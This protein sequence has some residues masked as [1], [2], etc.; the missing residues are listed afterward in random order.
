MGINNAERIDRYKNAIQSRFAALKAIDR[1]D[2]LVANSIRLPEG[3]GYLLCVSQLHVTDE[4][5]INLLAKWR[6]EATTFHNKFNV[7]FAS[8]ERWLRQLLLAVPDRILFLV[9]NR[10]GYPIGHMGF[11]NSLNDECMLEFD[12]VIRGV[13]GQDAGL[14]GEATKALLKWAG[15]IFQPQGFYLRTLDNNSHAIQF[16]SRL[17]FAMDGKQGL[18]RI[19][20]NG[21]INHVPLE[22]GDTDPPDRYFVRMRL[23]LSSLI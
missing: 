4:K 6:A 21:E 9:L 20:K 15:E 16:Y 3:K 23:D 7:T 14:M 8:T 13:P 17:G 18:R 12:N 5:M 22:A 10:Y 11:A 2:D 1:F 19:E